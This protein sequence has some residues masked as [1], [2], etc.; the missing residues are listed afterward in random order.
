MD[1][2]VFQFKAELVGYKPKMWRRFQIAADTTVAEL[3][4][5]VMKLYEMEGEH[6][7]S[8]L[9]I[10]R[11][12]TKSGRPGKKFEVIARFG[13]DEERWDD[14]DKMA[15]EYALFDLPLGKSA[16]LVVR[17]DFG[18]NWEVKLTLEK[19]LDESELGLVQLPR[20]LDGKGY[21]IIEDAGGAYGLM[22]LA[23]AIKTREGPVYEH[24]SEWLEEEDVDLDTF[25]VDSANSNLHAGT[26][27]LAYLYEEGGRRW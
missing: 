27:F 14:R 5:N 22:A 2:L 19:A 17:Y 8:I 7:L 15:T 23:E 18:D 24:Y 20:V 26:G 10:H 1:D 13:F 12:L 25:C 4:Y 11:G 3:A 21:G 16:F 6:L 9:L